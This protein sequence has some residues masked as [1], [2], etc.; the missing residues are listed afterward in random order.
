MAKAGVTAA[1]WM[2][3]VVMGIMTA[4]AW[5]QSHPLSIRDVQ[6]Q[7]LLWPDKVAT[8]Q[9][10]SDGRNDIP[11]GTELP[12]NGLDRQGAIVE[13]GAGELTL[14]PYD[15]TDLLDRAT[16]QAE[17]LPPEVRDLKLADLVQRTDLLPATV[18]LRETVQF[19]DKARQKGSDIGP[20][21]VIRGS[22]GSY[23][24]AAVDPE[25]AKAGNFAQRQSYTLPQTDFVAQLR[26]RLESGATQGESR[27]QAELKGRLVDANGEP[28]AEPAQPP[29]YYVIYHSAGWCGWCAK[30]NPTLTQF[31]DEVKAKHPDVEFVYLGSDKSEEQMLQHMQK[32]QMK[33][34]GVKFDQRTEV[35]FLLGLIT[36]ST[37]QVVVLSADG[38]TIHDGMPAGTKGA[39]AAL[40]ALRRE[41]A[42][43]PQ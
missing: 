15:A 6:A 13:T 12:L 18:K 14:L 8:R 2:G 33:F 7:P 19:D 11:A 4:C 26:K 22:D 32:A 23:L 42:K 43:T 28:A 30:F 27:I 31:H 20:Y 17:K 16:A 40:A 24:L 35:P 5:G 10:L 1:R 41:L 39:N 38:R 29:R 3:V 21:K 34:A 25:L 37:P 36:G 9:P